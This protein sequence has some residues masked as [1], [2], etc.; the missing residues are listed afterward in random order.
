MPQVFQQ[1]RQVFGKGGDEQPVPLSQHEVAAG[2]D[3]LAAPQHGTHQ[4]LAPDDALQ[5]HQA[6]VAQLAAGIYP[7]LNDLCAALGEG[8]PPEKARVFQQPVDL[9]G[10]LVLGIDEHGQ[11]EGLPHFENLL[12]VFRI[13]HPGDGVELL[14]HGVGRGAAEQ[15]YFVCTGGGDEQIGVLHTGLPQHIHGCAVALNGDHVVPLHTGFQGGGLGV[16]NGH[17]VAL[18]G[19]LTGQSGAD[20]AVACDNDFHICLR[21]LKRSTGFTVL[22][23]VKFFLLYHFLAENAIFFENAE[24]THSCVPPCPGAEACGVRGR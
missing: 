24:K 11:T 18:A 8:I 9:R 12:G 10:G 7:Q 23:T 2:G 14:V 1:G 17:V 20:L 13:P 22:K 3:G 15:V 5:I 4:D 6:D 21:F 19:E 16:D